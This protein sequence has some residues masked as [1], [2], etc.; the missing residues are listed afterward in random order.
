MKRFIGWGLAAL[1]IVV[2]GLGFWRKTHGV[3][4]APADTA[5]PVATVK[6]ELPKVQSVAEVIDALGDVS[7][8]QTSGLSFQR[9]GQITS[10]GVV[11]GD[12]FAKGAVLATLTPDPAVR[13]AYQA[14][15]DAVGLARRESDRQMLL[16][17]SHLATQSQ[18]DAA[19][20]VYRDAQGALRALDE[21][22]GGNGSSPLTAPFDGVVSTVVVVQGDRV[23]AGAPILQVGRTDLLRVLIGIEPSDRGRVRVGTRVTLWPV[24]GPST[25]S[26]PIDVA[27]SEV[28]E[29]V[30]PKTQLI[31]VVVMLPR[32]VASQLAPGMKAR[33]RLQVGALSA[34]AVPRNAVLTD[35]KGDYVFQIVTGKAQ[36][37]PVV[38]KV[39][40]GTLV[41]IDGIKDLKL[42]VVTEGNYELEDGMAVKDAAK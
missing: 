22:G 29:A 12:R 7:S 13:Q 19:D 10:L 33:A 27:L 21:Q 37:V 24:V 1:V 31:D 25:E 4:D 17:S 28:Q 35:E 2:A 15:I 8:G 9:A 32:A 5:A 11:A 6:S 23:Q 14:A 41:A 39:D 34:V 18:A 36:R 16:L 42:P 20:K 26:Q 3:A 38:K 30:D 40:N